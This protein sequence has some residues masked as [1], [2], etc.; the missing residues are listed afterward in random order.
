MKN[1]ELE[2]LIKMMQMALPALES[3]DEAPEALSESE[4]RWKNN[5]EVLCEAC[6]SWYHVSDFKS[7]NTGYMTV[8]DPVC[9]SC[10]KELEKTSYLA[11]VNCKEIVSRM[12][13]HKDSSGFVFEKNKVYH[14]SQCPKCVKNC[15]SSTLAEKIIH[16]RN[17]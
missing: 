1:K 6:H 11:C 8:F 15:I 14:M 5:Q 7:V 3:L 12:K 10:S 13:P 4:L 2:E 9:S 17:K 16:D